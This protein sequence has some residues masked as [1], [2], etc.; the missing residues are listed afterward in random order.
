MK[1]DN[2]LTSLWNVK[3][4]LESAFLPYMMRVRN[5]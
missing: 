3:C 5:Y 2:G 4:F 1:Q